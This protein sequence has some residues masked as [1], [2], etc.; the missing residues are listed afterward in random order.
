MPSDMLNST[1][2]A[3]ALAAF[4][5]T[6][7]QGPYTLAMSNSAIWISLANMTAD[8]PAI[9]S[10]IHSLSTSNGTLYLPP[11]YASDPTLVAGYRAQLSVLAELLGNP[12]APSL[13]SAI[14]TG[15]RL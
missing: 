11:D 10:R 7:A 2:R 5:E 15:T 3:W 9:I 12:H 13:E 6:P 14:A 4:N 8:A 1:F